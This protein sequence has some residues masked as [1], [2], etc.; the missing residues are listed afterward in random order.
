MY[1]ILR[2]KDIPY[3]VS[4]YGSLSYC[5]SAL[6]QG[7]ICIYRPGAPDCPPDMY[8]SDP[9]ASARAFMGHLATA[10]ELFRGMA[11]IWLE[12]TNECLST[13]MP[14]SQLEWWL[15]WMIAYTDRAAALGWP[16]LALPTL[17]PGNGDQLMFDIWK[18]ALLNLKAHGGLF[19]VHDYTFKSQTGLCVCDQWEACRHVLQQKYMALAGYDMPFTITEAARQSGGAPVDLADFECWIGK[20][21]QT[22]YVHSVWLWVGGHHATWPAANLDGHYVD[23]ARGVR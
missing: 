17:S 23:I 11:N 7:G 8:T 5:L 16:P 21:R 9:A 15:D 22:G 12:P 4:P 20:V 1:A 19:S 18:P 14:A 10:A 3:G 6:Q 2:A 13:P